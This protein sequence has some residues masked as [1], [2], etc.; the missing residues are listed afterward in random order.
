MEFA[1]HKLIRRAAWLVISSRFDLLYPFHCGRWL[2]RLPGREAVPVR[3]LAMVERA[4]LFSDRLHVLVADRAAPA[5]GRH[6]SPAPAA[7]R[8]CLESQLPQ[9]HVFWSFL[10]VGE[11]FAFEVQKKMG[12]HFI[13][14]PWPLG[15]CQP[16]ERFQTAPPVEPLALLQTLEDTDL[17]PPR[18]L[19]VDFPA[20]FVRVCNSLLV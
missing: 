12:A 9:S 16:E 19:Q 18:D 14:F 4:G 10:F 7:N 20:A 3:P 15:F 13:R 2:P 8:P 11:A 17:V 5:A 1:D 6:G